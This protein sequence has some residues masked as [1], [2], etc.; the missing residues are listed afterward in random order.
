MQSLIEIQQQLLPDVLAIMKKRYLILRQV[1]LS[2]MIGRRTLAASL[3]L[4]ERVLRAET[5]FLK[6]QGLLHV[7]TAGMRISES[8]RKL[9]EDL[10]PYYKEMFGL[11]ELEQRLRKH[12]G[13][14]HVWIVPG[15]SDTSPHTKRELGKAGAT[16]LRKMMNKDDV[17]AVTGGST[18]ASV[19]NQL[20]TQ[21]PLKGNWFVPARGGLGE[22]LDYQANTIV[23]TMAKRTGAHY[24]LLHVPDHLGEG[25][26]LTLMQEENIREV[27]D[28]IRSARIVI[29]GIGDAMVMARRRR[30]NEEVIEALK[31]E[32]ALA[33]S[34]GYYFDREGAVVHKMP[35]AGLRLEDILETEVVIAIA[36]GGSKGEAIA[37][38]MR[39]G[40]DDILVTDEAAALVIT[41][42]LDEEQQAS[43]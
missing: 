10:E 21:T 43:F 42:I 33:E 38:V 31:A 37:A 16:A 4:S 14:K 26:Y 40:H 9:L 36:G 20:T 30:V 28:V 27:V 12:F 34:F 3:D 24:R 18:L 15:D 2:D 13:L 7:E 29:H 11:T 1:M 23:S 32:G 8:G 22:S 35:T 6:E 17:I 19:A 25:A 5:D 39:F 41:A